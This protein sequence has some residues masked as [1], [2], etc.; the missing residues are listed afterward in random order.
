MPSVTLQTY[1]V[2]GEEGGIGLRMVQGRKKMGV[3]LTLNEVEQLIFDLHEQK[4]LYETAPGRS[5]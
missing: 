1:W 2:G 3:I 5:K 4:A